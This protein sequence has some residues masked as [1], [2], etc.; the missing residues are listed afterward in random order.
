[1]P[2]TARREYTCGACN[3]LILE[4]AP[5][6]PLVNEAGKA[7]IWAHL[8]CVTPDDVRIPICKHWRSKG[9]CIFR[10][11]CQFRHPAEECKG[12]DRLRQRHGTWAR[13]R[14]YN[15]GRAGSLRRWLVDIFGAEYLRSGS[16]VLDVA[17]GKGELS[18]E[19][20]NLSDICSTV[21]DP[22]P[23]EISRYRKKLHYGFYHNN[24]V[25]QAYNTRPNPGS[26]EQ[27]VIPPHMRMFFEVSLDLQP[28]HTHSSRDLDAD[29][30]QHTE[31][32]GISASQ[33]LPRLPSTLPNSLHD[34]EL[35]MSE[36]RRAISTAWTNKGLVHEDEEDEDSGKAVADSHSSGSNSKVGAP[37]AEPEG[38]GAF[39]ETTTSGRA[40]CVFDEAEDNIVLDYAEAVRIVSGCSVIVGMHPDQAAEHIVEFALRNGKPF[41]IV[42]C[43]VYHKQFPTRKLP[44]GDPVKKYGE[45]IEY[46]MAKHED[47][48]A[49]E[50]DFEGKN[51][52]LYYLG[53]GR[54]RI[55]ANGEPFQIPRRD[56]GLKKDLMC[57][58][59][60]T[61]ETWWNLSS[62]STRCRCT[63]PEEEGAC[64]E[65]TDGLRPACIANASTSTATVVANSNISI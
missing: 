38:D 30:A 60:A 59:K 63:E 9:M 14:I 10:D 18:F 25:L 4:G 7:L 23:L 54:E 51:V 45:L 43:C 27:H 48:K 57:R 24:Q 1:M 6:T 62:S 13:Y 37:P 47:I 56:P 20:G 65:N 58:G 2:L 53:D 52:L 29:D 15:E 11:T 21:A 61:K 55:D 50:M 5:V 46:L 22:R 34:A 36:S 41:A 35:F 8:D 16:G 3:G 12:S 26:F 40:S 17:G 32:E 31:P 28:Q 19:L 39:S 64:E 44:N 49:L 42:P 33:S